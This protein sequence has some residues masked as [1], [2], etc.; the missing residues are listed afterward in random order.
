MTS[1]TARP[2]NQGFVEGRMQ[3]VQP[4]DADLP[5]GIADLN[6]HVAAPPHQAEKI[7]ERALEPVHITRN[8]GAGRGARIWHGDP[9]HPADLHD[10]RGA[11]MLLQGLAAQFP[12]IALIWAHTAYRGLKDWLATALGWKLFIVKH[13]WTGLQ[14]VW[15]APGQAP[16]EVPQGFHVLPRRWVFE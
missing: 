11:E 14:G 16:P 9:L 8:Q 13:W 3:V 15:V 1:T 5:G 12:L 4:H 6:Y 2:P 10:R 7:A